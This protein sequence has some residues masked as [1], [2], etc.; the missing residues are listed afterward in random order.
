GLSAIVAGGCGGGPLPSVETS[1][2]IYGSD[3]RV[4]AFDAAPEIQEIMRESVVALIPR[5]NLLFTGNQ[6]VL[7][8][9]TWGEADAFCPQERFSDQFAVAFCTGLLV[10]WD[11]VLTAGHCVRLFALEDFVVAFDYSYTALGQL[12]LASNAIMNPTEIVS[13]RLDPVGADPQL[14]YAWLRLDRSA[15]PP[16]RPLPIFAALPSLSAGDPLTVIS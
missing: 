5:A 11:L 12:T 8:A 6:V 7:Q 9:P 3:D 13:E 15:A 2:L 4:E 14:D 16:R 1:S 10:D